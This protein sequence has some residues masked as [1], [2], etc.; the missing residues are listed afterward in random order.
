MGWRGKLLEER[1]WEGCEFAH[2]EDGNGARTAPCRG[3]S[4]GMLPIEAEEL[5]LEPRQ[6]PPPT[7]PQLL[8]SAGGGCGAAEATRLPAATAM[9]FN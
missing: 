2:C 5:K 1:E 3:P 9:C 8:G 4:T 7:A 6:P